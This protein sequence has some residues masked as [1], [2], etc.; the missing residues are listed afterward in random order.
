MKYIRFLAVALLC[1]L[2]LAVPVM[3][4]SGV[5]DVTG[6]ATVDTDGGCHISMTVQLHLDTAESG[7]A[8]P[9]PADATNILLNGQAAQTSAD[10]DKLQVHLQDLPAGDHTLA[11][12]YNL[13][14]QVQ[15]VKGQTILTLPL[16]CGFPMDI[17]HFTFTLTLPGE[18]T[19]SAMF[20]SGYHQENIQLD[21]TVSGNTLTST[22]LQPLKDH[23]TLTLQL[24]V[25]GEVF[26]LAMAKERLLS[27]WDIAALA[28]LVL[29]MLYY[30]LGLLP[31]IPRISRSYTAPEGITAGEVGSC[32]TGCG[33]DLT[34]MTLS[35]A[36]LGYILVEQTRN[37]RILLHKRMEMGNERSYHEGR[38]FQLLF[39]RRM[40]VEATGPHFARLSRKVAGRSP[41]LKQLFKPTSGD[42]RIFRILCCGAGFCCGVQMISGGFWSF[43]LG[44]LAAVLSYFI[45]SGGKCIPLRNKLPLLLALVCGGLWL[46][47]GGLTH[48][49]GHV[50]PV[51]IFQYVAGVFAAYGGKRSELGQ[52]VLAQMLG[53]RRHM[54][55]AS[56]F[57]MQ[58]LYQKNPNYFHELVP[59]AL[60][61]GVDRQFARRFDS[62]T[63]LPD[64]GWLKD[65]PAMNAQQWA[66]RLRQVADSIQMACWKH[67]LRLR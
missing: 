12:Q 43:V 4:L 27:R 56:S 5:A 17:E 66:L 32:M 10:G 28:L 65:A 19:G 41:L 42:V 34:M 49:M 6:S 33:T 54:T 40:T 44:L 9:L 20:T 52:R 8:F 51:W 59:Y 26:D 50:I 62:K 45:Q 18:I 11:L 25:D 67:S 14:C 21:T 47:L 7:L 48:S 30:C 24:P 15:S 46:L 35:W 2:L 16:L 63:I 37:G 39:G 29:A 61:M 3:A 53:L 57:D 23:E 58:L 38:I 60:A 1:C 64:S 55:S 31:K 13:P 36:E 22:M